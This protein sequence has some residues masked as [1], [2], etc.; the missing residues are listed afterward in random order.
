MS[1]EE[2]FDAGLAHRLERAG[3]TLGAA[4]RWGSETACASVLERRP[5]ML[6]LDLPRSGDEELAGLVRAASLIAPVAV[7]RPDGRDAL[8]AFGAGALDVLDRHAPAAELAGRIYAD[9]RRCIP[10]SP[11]RWCA[12]TSASQRLLFD[13]ISRA[14]APICCHR[15]RL[16]LGTPS[17]P[18]TLRALKARIQRLLPAF[19]DCGLELVA[20]LQWGL[21]TY[22]VR[23]AKTAD[24]RLQ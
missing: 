1:V 2:T 7:L 23:D 16:L 20:D 3:L 19:A 24:A 14:Q 12:G 21:A 13:V 5:A 10:A 6:L 15:L 4:V 8:T 9:L 22:R 18:L 11:T 17:L